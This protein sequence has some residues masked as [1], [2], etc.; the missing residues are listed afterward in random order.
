M[1]VRFDLDVVYPSDSIGPY[2]E[3]SGTVTRVDAEYGGIDVEVEEGG[4][5]FVVTG[6]NELYR[7]RPE[8]APRVGYTAQ[9]RIYMSGG[10]FYPDNKIMGWRSP[11]A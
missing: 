2:V 1:S 11:L 3:L 7:Q 4:A 10:G 8:H 9:V 6:Y 5:P